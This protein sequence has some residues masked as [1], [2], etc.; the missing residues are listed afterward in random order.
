MMKTMGVIILAVTMAL[1]CFASLA[2]AEDVAEVPGSTFLSIGLEEEIATTV[3][4]KKDIGKW[5]KRSASAIPAIKDLAEIAQGSSYSDDEAFMEYIKLHG[6]MVNSNQEDIKGVQSVIADLSKLVFAMNGRMKTVEK[7]L[8]D[9][10][11]NIKL[12]VNPTAP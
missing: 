10:E 5:I 3:S 7:Q 4:I 12:I 6:S 1:P 11:K 2:F 9:I 8:L